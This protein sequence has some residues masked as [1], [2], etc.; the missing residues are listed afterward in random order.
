MSR[1]DHLISNSTTSASPVLTVRY[2]VLGGSGFIGSHLVDAL[3][4][5]GG[6]VR[7]FGRPGQN[8]RYP[9]QHPALER[10]DG[11]F[12]SERDVREAVHGCNVVYHLV[13]TTLPGPSNLN[14]ISDVETNLV[15]TLRLL[16]AAVEEGVSHLV[17]VS[18]G[19]TVYGI[20]E[21]LPITENHP[22]TPLC[23]YGITKLAIEKYLQLYAGLHGIRV[24]VLRLSN[25]FGERQRSDSGQG[26]VAAFLGRVLR[27]E[28][29]DIWGDGTVVR[30]YVH[31]SDVVSAMVRVLE[32]HGPRQIFN[33]GSGRGTSL[34]ALLDTIEQVTGAAPARRYLASRGFDVPT[35]VLGIDLARSEL[36]WEPQLA[37]EQGI[38]RTWR[39]LHRQT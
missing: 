32:Y 30:D 36:G 10:V 31:V 13:S 12:T 29:I 16:N 39:W 20:P 7:C 11:D 21:S 17:F 23:S 33:I 26:A 27:N 24:T 15:A 35:N 25:P 22:T 38:E 37:L 8:E 9:Y 1:P 5:A 19:G 34:N 14:P 6:T 4:R 3:V 28:P 2:L 18:S